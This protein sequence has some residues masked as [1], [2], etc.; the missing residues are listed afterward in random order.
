MDKTSKVVSDIEIKQKMGMSQSIDLKKYTNQSLRRF[1][2]Y[3]WEDGSISVG[4]ASNKMDAVIQLDEIGSAEEKRVKFS[5][6]S[7][8]FFTFDRVPAEFP[9][10]GYDNDFSYHSCQESQEVASVLSDWANKDGVFKEKKGK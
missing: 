10:E 1:F 5:Y 8:F 2:Y 3:V 7:S 9:E 4:I 6:S